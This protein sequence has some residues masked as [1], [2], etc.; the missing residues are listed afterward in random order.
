M[1]I[2]L[3]LSVALG[4]GQATNGPSLPGAIKFIS[5]A[6]VQIAYKMDHF[7][8]ETEHALGTMHLVGAAGTGFVVNEDGYIVTGI[9]RTECLGPLPGGISFAGW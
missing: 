5:P 4:F 8:P 2:F 9:T 1:P 3:L 7:P 6:V